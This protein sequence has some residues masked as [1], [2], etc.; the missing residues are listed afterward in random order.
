MSIRRAGIRH[1]RAPDVHGAC[2]PIWPP[3]NLPGCVAWYDML[4]TY[5]ESGGTVTAIRNMVTG[6]DAM[7][8]ATNPPA[9]NLTGINGLPCMVPDGTND[10]LISTEAPV[11]QVFNNLVSPLT[12]IAVCSLTSLAGARVLFGAGNS[13]VASSSSHTM[14]TT[15]SLG[16]VLR[17]NR[18]GDNGVS[19]TLN[20]T[21]G[22]PLGVPFVWSAGTNGNDGFHTVNLEPTTTSIA[23]GTA[24]A[25]AGLVTANRTALFCRPDSA[26]DTF[27]N[28]P[29]GCFLLYSRRLPDSELLGVVAALMGRWLIPT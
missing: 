22:I 7:S 20:R 15:I 18:I 27:G 3:T 8:E 29:A 19:T 10:R 12:M 21:E 24:F 9:L 13:G 5:T 11:F 6:S 17:Q 1:V 14:Q 16:G 2:G 23:T 28:M 25:R 26:P 4:E